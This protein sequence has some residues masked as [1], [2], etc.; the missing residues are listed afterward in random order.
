MIVPHTP[1]IWDEAT[2][3]YTL[4]LF[5]PDGYYD[6]LKLLDRVLGE[7]RREMEGAGKW[8]GTA[9]LLLSDHV[10]RYRPAYLNEPRDSR[11]PFI[12]KLPGATTGAVY[13]RRFSAMVTHD[14]VAALLRGELQSVNQATAWLDA[15]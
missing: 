9:V 11:I 5:H 3:S 1:W 10:M 14:L 15:R 12:L 2:E 6:N 4:T 7:L 13:D 8:D